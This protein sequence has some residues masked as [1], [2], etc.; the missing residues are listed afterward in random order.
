M[1]NSGMRE[2]PPLR[3]TKGASINR[4]LIAFIL[5]LAGAAYFVFVRSSEPTQDATAKDTVTETSPENETAE[6]SPPAEEATASQETASSA[7]DQSVSQ[8]AS[9]KTEA[10]AEGQAPVSAPAVSSYVSHKG[11]TLKKIALKL[12]GK[13]DSVAALAKKNPTIKLKQVLPAGVTI[14]LPAELKPSPKK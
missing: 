8:D 2:L 14:L 5:I 6:A 12:Y 10:S 7:N 1:K 9:P 3:R 13:A 11:D 4:S